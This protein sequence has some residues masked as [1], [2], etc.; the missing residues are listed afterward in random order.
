MLIVES[1][2]LLLAALGAPMTAQEGDPPPAVAQ[3]Q[4]SILVRKQA[5]LDLLS[6]FKNAVAS[7]TFDVKELRRAKVPPE[8]WPE[9]PLGEYFLEFRKLAETGNGDAMLW[10]IENMRDAVPSIE[11]RDR[12]TRRYFTALAKNHATEDF[13]PDVIE[14]LIPKRKSLG[15]EYVTGVLHTISENCKNPETES[16]ALLGEARVLLNYGK[17]RSP[18]DKQNG[19]D[20]M[21]I[22]VEGYAGSKAALAAAEHLYRRAFRMTLETQQEWVKAARALQADG[23]GPEGW[24]PHPIEALHIEFRSLAATG[25]FLSN[26]WLEG[27]YPG[28]SKAMAAGIDKGLIF[29][30]DWIRQTEQPKSI[31]WQGLRFEMLTLLVEAFP[32]QPWVHKIVVEMG[33]VVNQYT[34]EEYVP[35]LRRIIEL[36]PEAR[37]RYEAQLVMAYSLE[38]GRTFEEL[39]EALNS[40]QCVIDESP[41]ERQRKEA[42][43]ALRTFRLTMPGAPMPPF[44]GLDDDGLEVKSTGYQGKVLLLY[45]WSSHSRESREDL[46]WVNELYAKYQDTEKYPDTVFRLLGMNVD[47]T[48]RQLFRRV[49]RNHGVTWRNALLQSSTGMVG[50]QFRV[51]SLPAAFV[52]DPDGMIR[53][54]CLSHEKTEALIEELLAEDAKKRG[55]GE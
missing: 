19:E 40:Y 51:S 50:A 47:V 12:I 29:I 31:Y 5:Y 23:V 53:G 10:V 52:I 4:Q 43:N 14:Q 33:N 39:N 35:V 7:Y 9:S 24:P 20:L 27:F 22:L 34:P 38:R 45:F 18:A 1:L 54:R 25:H 6:K 46:P 44:Q 3:D 16:A 36:V 15:A 32:D 42:E 21:L 28:Y 11:E 30:C 37:T 48:T 41:V 8:R 17:P 49:C 26:R 13:I 55:E 2:F